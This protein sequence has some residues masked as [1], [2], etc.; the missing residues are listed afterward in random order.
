[1]AESE[2]EVEEVLRE[3]RLRIRS[4]N[5]LTS[6]SVD[7]VSHRKE[8]EIA[9]L[10]IETYL[11]MTDRMRNN[12]PPVRT[13]RSGLLAR[14]ELWIKRQI[15]RSTHWFTL[16]QVNFNS[17]IHN[18]L[19]ELREVQSRHEEILSSL[20]E[21]AQRELV[22]FKEE[23]GLVNESLALQ[24]SESAVIIDR[25]RRNFEHRLGKI[26]TSKKNVKV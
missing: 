18:I 3:I 14:I 16:D 15:K 21:P 5:G 17:A 10:R 12:L 9:G 6:D 26:E 23:Q 19:T 13:Y 7:L 24:I 22:R 20:Q 25:L 2:L 4:E 8:T 11:S 1:M